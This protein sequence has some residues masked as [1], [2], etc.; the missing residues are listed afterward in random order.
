MRHVSYFI[1]LMLC[2]SPAAYAQ[3]KIPFWASSGNPSNDK[4]LGMPENGQAAMLSKATRYGCLGTNP[5]YMGTEIRGA[6]KGVSFW[7]IT[8]SNGGEK[9]M[10]AIA[11]DDTGS[12]KVISCSLL[13]GH[14]WECYKKLRDL[15][16]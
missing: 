2:V 5:F 16:K 9:F 8:C 11:P 1:S 7:S 15:P 12:T 13:H 4:L 14:P 10:I 3:E 6:N